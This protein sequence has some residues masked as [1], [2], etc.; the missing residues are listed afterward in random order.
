MT[1]RIIHLQIKLF[2]APIIVCVNPLTP[3]RI[4]TNR[5][6]FTYIAHGVA[7]RSIY[8][9]SSSFVGNIVDCTA[10]VDAICFCGFNSIDVGGE[11]D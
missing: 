2:L 7:D 10:P 4:R 3:G 6:S 9:K 11:E 8:L 5:A 1:F